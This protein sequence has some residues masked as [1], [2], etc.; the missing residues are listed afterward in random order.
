MHQIDLLN[1]PPRAED[2]LT[3]DTLPTQ[4]PCRSNRCRFPCTLAVRIW[5][6]HAPC[7]KVFIR[8]PAEQFS[9]DDGSLNRLC[10]T[11]GVKQD[12][13]ESVVL[14]WHAEV[15]KALGRL[16]RALTKAHSRQLLYILAKHSRHDDDVTTTY[17]VVE[18]AEELNRRHSYLEG[19]GGIQK[20]LELHAQRK[21]ADAKL[22]QKRSINDPDIQGAAE[23]TLP[24]DPI[25][26]KE[27]FLA[28]IT[29]KAQLQHE[30]HELEHCLG[31][32]S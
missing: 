29:T 25:T 10:Q 3:T 32:G 9:F 6:K 15:L 21:M 31:K 30:S 24:K 26:G 20:L 7:Y 27:F 5:S 23:V 16:G 19:K 18:I 28:K 8:M 14:P 17:Y 11:A 13:C 2:Q 1:R 22:L 12:R 4:C